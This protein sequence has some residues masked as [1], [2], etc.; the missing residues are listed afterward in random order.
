[1]VIASL[2]V[3][4]VGVAFGISGMVLGIVALARL[5]AAHAETRLLQTAVDSLTNRLITAVAEAAVARAQAEAA[6]TCARDDGAEDVV[7]TGLDEPDA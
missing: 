3:G 7:E 4:I 1:M 5:H 6:A 2:V